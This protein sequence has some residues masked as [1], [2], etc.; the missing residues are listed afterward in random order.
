MARIFVSKLNAT[1]CQTME[2]YA[3]MVLSMRMRMR[4][5][6]MAIL[7][8]GMAAMKIVQ[9]PPAAMA[10]SALMKSVMKAKRTATPRLTS[11]AS[12]VDCPLV[13]MAKQIRMKAVTMR[14]VCR[15]N[16]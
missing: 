13:V 5:V 11:V 12:I 4:L 15:Q 10:S 16:S 8:T 6:M 1:R 7:S 9:Q 3:G 14:P 2:T